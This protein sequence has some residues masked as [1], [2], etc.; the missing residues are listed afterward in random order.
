MKDLRKTK[1]Q[2][3]EEIESLRRKLDETQDPKQNLKN[4]EQNFYEL[5]EN[6][7]IGALIVNSDGIISFVN[8]EVESLF[9]YDRK[10]LIGQPL[11]ILI[12]HRYRKEYVEERR[13]Y[14][15]NPIEAKMG[16]GRD[17]CGLK[18]DETEFPIEIGLK[19][20]DTEEDRY[21]F[22][23]IVDITKRKNAEK[24]LQSAHEEVKNWAH[25]KSEELDKAN[26]LL[27][28]AL[29]ERK[30][31]E[32]ALR[33]SEEKYRTIVHTAKEGIWILNDQHTTTFVNEVIAEMLGYSME[34]IL[35]K[36]LF[37]FMSEE[38]QRVVKAHLNR[39][40]N[41][42][43]EQHYLKFFRNKGRELW[44]IF[45]SRPLY[46]KTGKYLGAMAT[47]IDITERK[48]A[49]AQIRKLSMAVEQATSLII[50]T[51][52]DGHIDYVNAKFTEVTGYAKEEVMGKN[53]RILKSNQTP[54]SVYE[55]LWK[56][57]ANGG[58][59]H[60]EL[61]NRKKNGESYWA[62]ASISPIKNSDG[63]VTHYLAVQ[64]DTTD[65]KMAEHAL[66]NYAKELERSNE[67]LQ[68]FAYV[69]SHD[70]QEPLRM[71][72]SYLTLLENRYSGQ[73]DD[74]AHE[75][76][77]YA[78]NGAK[79]MKEL[80]RDLLQFSKIG[81]HGNPFTDTDCEEILKKTLHNLEVSIIENQTS[82][83]H[84]PLP[85]IHSDPVQVS[86][87]FQNLI[88]NSIK[89]RS[90]NPPAIHI[91][92]DKKDNDWVFSV[93]DNGIGIEK[94][95]AKRIFTI[96]QRLHSDSK[97]PGTGIGLA[98][99]KKIVERHGGRIW[100]ESRSGGGSVFYFTMPSK[101]GGP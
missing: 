5:L 57:I 62:R 80:I 95:Y 9:K 92:A 49:E 98:L 36:S 14:F 20:I 2:L 53:P 85:V 96:F 13:N 3:I 73:L 37:S 4:T 71:I 34:E 27:K 15:V 99:C 16:S 63:I 82:I 69:A 46:G 79:R 7:P 60:G 75:F 74:D 76:I 59:W 90:S 47:I 39:R 100:F 26:L 68:Q 66:Q 55:D 84:D 6:S 48:L 77:G 23:S 18:S 89:F 25:I 12:P 17:L 93:K 72:A 1:R 35:N 67:E 94:E 54:K 88:S 10:D 21:A 33:E 29:S 24:M 56:V 44:T 101:N 58:E 70:L 50:I 65:R 81:T 42:I 83:T 97:Y 38:S 8:S 64:E 41:G 30:R 28:E 45:S 52:T 78:V 31:I 87:L 51:D 86:Q 61:H 43:I 91:S 32:K 11:E 40:Q 19:F 22:C